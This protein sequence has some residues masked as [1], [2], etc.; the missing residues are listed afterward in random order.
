MRALRPLAYAR[1]NA[2]PGAR[3]GAIVAAAAA[4]ARVLG[5]L[6][7]GQRPAHGGATTVSDVLKVGTVVSRHTALAVKPGHAV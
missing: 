2:R 7:L 5:L 1:R 3:S 4:L 6:A